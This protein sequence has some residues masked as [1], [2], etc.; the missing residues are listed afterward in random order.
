[1]KALLSGGSG[2]PLAGLGHAVTGLNAADFVYY[3][4]TSGSEEGALFGTAGPGWCPGG[5]P[6]YT[7]QDACFSLDDTWYVGG[8]LQI[9]PGKG[10]AARLARFIT[11]YLDNNEGAEL[12][13]VAHSQGG[14]LMAFVLSQP[15]LLS[16]SH[17]ARIKSVVTIDGVLSGVPARVAHSWWTYC[18]EQQ[19]GYDSTFDMGYESQ[20]IATNRR[21]PLGI[22]PPLYTI[23]AEP[24]DLGPANRSAPFNRDETRVP[25][26]AA[27][28]TVDSPTHSGV[29]E[30]V[31]GPGSDPDHFEDSRFKAFIICA[32]A[33]RGDCEAFSNGR[34]RVVFPNDLTIES[35][36]VPSTQ[37]SLTA[38]TFVVNEMS[39]PLSSNLLGRGL[40]ATGL[41]DA[42][43]VTMTLVEPGPPGR[44]LT[45]DSETPD[46][47]ASCTASSAVLDVT[48]PVSG[49]WSVEL[50]GTDDLP[51]EG[52]AMFLSFSSSPSAQFDEDLDGVADETDNCPSTWNPSQADAA[53]DGPGDAC[54]EDDDNDGVVDA[55]DN[56]PAT[57]NPK[58]ADW[59][60]G[61]L[62]DMCDSDMGDTD[63]D[64]CIDGQEIGFE[65]LQGGARNS[66]VF[67][68]FIDTPDED[69]VRD[70]AVTAG[71]IARVVERF[72]TND[73]MQGNFDRNSD[74]L[75]AP[76]LAP[77][78]HP[79][80]DRGGSAGPAAWNL[81]PPDG[82]ITVG[83]LG[84]VVA[85]FGHSC[86]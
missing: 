38:T 13:V 14:T 28:I 40:E 42:P 63:G 45:C 54:D 9:Q 52:Q 76:G 23:D 72:G 79:A 46:L 77:S 51:A 34:S 68:D 67:W 74:P 71:D 19:A 7:R 20:V 61:G 30:G 22:L 53:E 85:Q 10:Q 4:Y 55:A 5:S 66:V 83:D 81:L 80:F 59:N 2:E 17:K 43:S 18:E 31:T 49:E 24:G 70:K 29:W 15:A 37:G 32:V 41:N 48:D 86:A 65:P 3:P 27:H 78:Y 39:I 58:Q 16:E 8:A 84:A 12:S 56:C 69:N 73:S 64:G 47:Q 1:M 26:D 36:D 11:N 50:S 35:L 60:T 44:R 25:W 21:G 33:A 75:S 57:P 62:G 6:S 82:S